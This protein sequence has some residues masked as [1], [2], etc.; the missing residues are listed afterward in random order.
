MSKKVPF[1]PQRPWAVTVLLNTILLPF[2]LYIK[3]QESSGYSLLAATAVAI[4]LANSAWGH[5]FLAFW[6]SPVAL[7]FQGFHAETHLLH[8]INDGLMTF[9]FIE[10]GL[11]IKREI[12]EGELSSTRKAL[13]PAIA[14]LGG[15]LV[16]ALIFVLCNFN[17]DTKQ[18]WGIPTATDIA[19]SLTIISLLGNKIPVG[20]KIFLA[21]LAIVDD[22]GAIVLIALFYSTD[23]Q[24][25][26]LG[27]GLGVFALLM[28]LN[29]ARIDNMLPYYL[30]G[31]FLWICF[32]KSGIHPTIAGVL[33]AIAIPHRRKQTFEPKVARALVALEK[34][35]NVLQSDRCRKDKMFRDQ[36]LEEM[37]E[38]S[39]KI[40]S[41]LQNLLHTLHPLSGYLIMPLFALANAGVVFGEVSADMLFNPLA[42]GIILG[43][44][45]GKSLGIMLAS[46]L[47]VKTNLA[48]LPE[49]VDFMKIYGMAWL[50]GIGFTM[51]IFIAN[52]ALQPGDMLLAKVAILGASAF[53]GLMG[54]LILNASFQKEK[55]A[56]N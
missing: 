2:N 41:P 38:V 1:N 20:L 53:S 56:A 42:L 30:L 33:F 28:T 18:G 17:S 12:S 51:S 55:V 26:A 34:H 25:F 10:V 45:L 47:A 9:F 27:T 29:V 11:E 35:L 13:L 46:W 21:A 3:F 50:A 15:M 39:R 22:L 37:Q 5:S 24:W 36:V 19:F 14:A 31:I 7:S 44:T 49:N 23:I 40:E 4:L 16:P 54:Y 6:Q 8:I 52:L 32:L 43:L 48:K